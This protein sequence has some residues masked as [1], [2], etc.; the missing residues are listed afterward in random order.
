LSAGFSLTIY[1][2]MSLFFEH[3]RNLNPLEKLEPI[4]ALNKDE[5]RQ[6]CI[7]CVSHLRQFCNGLQLCVMACHKDSVMS[8]TAGDL[9]EEKEY[10][11]AKD[12]PPTTPNIF[13]SSTRGI[14]GP[15]YKEIENSDAESE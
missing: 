3:F 1:E 13:V 12:Q 10:F 5:T 9:E 7:S 4:A 15:N 2:A 11:R 14:K 6:I 8:A